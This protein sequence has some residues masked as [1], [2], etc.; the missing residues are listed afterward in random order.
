MQDLK[1]KK[2]SVECSSSGVFVEGMLEALLQGYAQ[3]ATG[4]CF[5]NWPD[6]IQIK[7]KLLISQINRDI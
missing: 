4:K 6:W 3:S 1:K 5:R 7:A 2:G